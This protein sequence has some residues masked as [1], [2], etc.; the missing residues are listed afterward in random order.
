[1][2]RVVGIKAE[3]AGKEGLAGPARQNSKK[4]LN[5][6]I[7]AD[8]AIT[9]EVGVAHAWGRGACA[10]KAGEEGFDVLVGADVAVAVVI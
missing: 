9:I 4:A 6:R 2:C 3:S 10:G 1:M 8:I 5:V 7:G